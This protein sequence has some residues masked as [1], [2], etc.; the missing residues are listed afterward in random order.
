MCKLNKE[1]PKFVWF[2]EV[3]ERVAV[4]EQHI[5]NSL[6]HV[7]RPVIAKIISLDGQY[8]S[9]KFIRRKIFAE[10]YRNE[11][12]PF[13]NFFYKKKTKFNFNLKIWKSLT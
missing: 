8:I 11:L 1:K 12:I 7:K 3:G 10:F 13:G 5:P 2:P 9:V 6:K 4:P